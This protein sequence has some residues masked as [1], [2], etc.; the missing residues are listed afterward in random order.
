MRTNM[1]EM[2]ALLERVAEGEA[3]R[4]AFREG[5]AALAAAVRDRLSHGPGEAHAAPWV[6]SGAL[7]DSVGE[8]MD[9]DGWRGVVGSG[10]AAAAP[11]ELGTL[12]V[13]ARP[14]LAPVAAERGEALAERVRD[15]VAEA[16]RTR[17]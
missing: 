3:T 10:D 17:F 8:M 13:P 1:L 9:G 15:G 12:H 14:F 2:A 4:V 6:Q 5:A 11:Q 7:R 16:F